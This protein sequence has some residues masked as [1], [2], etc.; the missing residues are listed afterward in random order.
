[1]RGVVMVTPF[2]SVVVH[3]CYPTTRSVYRTRFLTPA[4]SHRLS[5]RSPV[6][7]PKPIPLTAQHDLKFG[8]R[9]A[10]TMVTNLRASR[11]T[12]D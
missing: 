6:P 9:S 7:V 4:E 8:S 2:S 1:M 10:P 11:S 3:K 12:G 5:R